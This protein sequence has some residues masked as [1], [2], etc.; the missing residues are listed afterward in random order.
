MIAKST[1]P[2]AELQ[3]LLLELGFTE[4]KR[5]KFWFFEHAPSE[6]VF[7]FRPYRAQE[8][9]TVKDLYLTRKHL[10]WRGVLSANA[11]DEMLKQASA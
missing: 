8:K 6:T 3:R 9:I 10:D 5:G 1:V 2:F 4:S 11:F 7:A